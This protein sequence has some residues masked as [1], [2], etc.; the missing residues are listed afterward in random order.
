[1]LETSHDLNLNLHLGIATRARSRLRNML[2]NISFVALILSLIIFEQRVSSSVL[3]S[4][5]EEA[6]LFVYSL[7]TM[8]DA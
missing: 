4:L 3:P 5:A 1:M 8:L 6:P 2:C 7:P